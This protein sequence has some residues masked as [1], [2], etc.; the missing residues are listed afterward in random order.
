MVWT[1]SNNSSKAVSITSK[2]MISSILLSYPKGKR[3][4]FLLTLLHIT[5]SLD[6]AFT[7][8]SNNHLFVLNL[9][10]RSSLRET[11]S[12]CFPCPPSP[13]SS[14][15]CETTLTGDHLRL[16]LSRASNHPLQINMQK[17]CE[18]AS[19]KKSVEKNA[20]PNLFFKS[21]KQN[22]FVAHF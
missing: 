10:S 22:S 9:I 17:K 7:G 21:H 2:F 8:N 3:I 14:L 12:T 16:V 1:F 15:P 18:N 13:W 5:I 19:H 4:L 20:S 11:K 6:L